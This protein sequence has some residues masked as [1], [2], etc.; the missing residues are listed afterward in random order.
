M[1]YVE[2][3]ATDEMPDVIDEIIAVMDSAGFEFSEGKILGRMFDE[4]AFGLGPDPLEGAR[5]AFELAAEKLEYLSHRHQ[6]LQGFRFEELKAGRRS[7]PGLRLA[8]LNGEALDLNEPA[9]DP[10]PVRSRLHKLIALAISNH[11]DNLAL[12]DPAPDEEASEIDGDD[13][14]VGL[15]LVILDEMRRMTDQEL[16][17]RVGYLEG[18]Y[19]GLTGERAPAMSQS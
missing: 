2:F 17:T 10:K 16:C 18:L 19:I 12:S 1:T 14:Y 6:H 3:F 13:S 7:H 8:T 4:P 5:A 9:P 15:A 11:N